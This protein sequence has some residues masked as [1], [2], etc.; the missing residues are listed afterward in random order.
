MAKTT[1]DK[2]RAWTGP[3]LF[4][5]GFRPFFLFGAVWAA[6][7]MI[8]WIAQLADALELPSS[9]DSVSWHA[10]EF[11]FGYLSAVIAGFL[12]TAVPNWTGRMPVVGWGLAVLFAI[13]LAGRVAL[14]T[15]AWWPGGVAEGVDLAFSI[16]LGGVILREILAGK[17]WRNL[18]VLVLLA[19]FTV[20]NLTFHIEAAQGAYAAQGYGLRLGVAA[21]VLMI[22]LI[23]GRIVPSFTRNWLAKQQAVRLPVPPMQQFDKAVMVATTAALALW[24]GVPAHP[25]TGVTLV[26]VG[27]LHLIRLIRWEG[28]QALR[29]PL[30]WVLHLGY[31]FIPLGALVEGVSI[32]RPEWLTVTGAQHVWM[33]GAFGLMTVAVMTRATL[34]HTGQDLRADTATLAIYLGLIGAVALR[35]AAAVWP[36][37]AS[38]LYNISGLLWI[39]AFG[40]FALIY[41]RLLLRPKPAKA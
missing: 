29:E 23:G 8:L 15:S 17:N 19:V 34:G 12:L 38:L 24:V 1:S 41:G 9:L 16:V 37:A 14:A 33:A 35:V 25:L 7:A 27:A 2:M 10:H 3:A 26:L 5:Y 31:A 40:G 21:V 22:A 13:W 36:E 32:L 4:T 18:V 6:L 28:A 39:G 20:A 11:L 30:L